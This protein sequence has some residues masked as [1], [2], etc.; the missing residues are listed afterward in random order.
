MN[1]CDRM[2]VPV[3]SR[4]TVTNPLIP[5][6]SWTGYAIGATTEPSILVRDEDTG[7]RMMLPLAWA[8]HAAPELCQDC[9]LPRTHQD[10]DDPGEGQDFDWDGEGPAWTQFWND[11][12]TTRPDG[13]PFM[14]AH[15]G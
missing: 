12:H 10:H 3:G 1:E 4:V 8:A 7:E 2:M 14:G 13:H 11:W 5:G 6:V 15:R 9:G